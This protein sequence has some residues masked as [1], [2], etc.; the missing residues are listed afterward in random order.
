MNNQELNKF[1]RR[2]NSLKSDFESGKITEADMTKEEAMLLSFIYQLE[3]IELETQ[4]SCDD[5]LLDNYK[6]R[7]KTAIEYLKKKK[8]F[9][10]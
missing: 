3:T 5:A 10:L 9:E 6:S 4:I 2:F 1:E 8:N 7:L